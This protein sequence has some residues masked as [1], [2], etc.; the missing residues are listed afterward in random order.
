LS[1][2][3]RHAGLAEHSI[4]P[5]FGRSSSSHGGFICVGGR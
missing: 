2:A 3:A 5:G 4:K 1:S